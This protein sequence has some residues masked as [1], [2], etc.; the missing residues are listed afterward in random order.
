MRGQSVT[1]T[2]QRL[3]SV[4][5][6]VAQVLGELRALRAQV[7]CDDEVDLRRMLRRRGL[8]WKKAQHA[9][10]LVPADAAAAERFYELLRHYSFRLFLRDVIKH[11]ER[12][13]VRDLLRYCSEATARRYLERLVADGLVRRRGRRYALSVEAVSFGPTLEWFVASALERE[14]GMRSA[15]NVRLDGSRGGGDY[16]VLGFAESTCVYIETKASPPRNIEQRQIGAFLDR[17]ETLRP[18][19]A[20]FLND[21]QLRM[22][23]KIALLFADALRRRLGRRAR[24]FPVVR[25]AAEIFRVGDG[26]FISNSDPDLI[27]NLGVCLAQH[28]RRDGLHLDDA[29]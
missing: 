14:F 7:A 6:G 19:I 11:R 23:D 25:L 15:W 12:F 20:I 24:A 8:C 9:G 13:G 29:R 10:S 16:D 21:T 28:F 17:L 22:R 27:A 1:S 2:Q 3:T 18:H 5:H 4:E 26:L